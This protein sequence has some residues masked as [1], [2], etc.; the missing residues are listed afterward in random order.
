MTVNTK[1]EYSR[2]GTIFMIIVP[3]GGGEGEVFTLSSAT[4]LLAHLFMSIIIE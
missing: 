1:P 4:R 3:G 2:P